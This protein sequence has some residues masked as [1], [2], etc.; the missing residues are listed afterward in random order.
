[1]RHTPGPWEYQGKPGY[2]E[3][4]NWF[5]DLWGTS[6][7]GRP[8]H[9]AD[10]VSE[11]DASLLKAAPDLLKALEDLLVVI[12]PLGWERHSGDSIERAHY[13]IY[14]A[15]GAPISPVRFYESDEQAMADMKKLAEG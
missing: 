10:V 3:L 8:V 11:Q 1:M 14:K 15:S 13:A 4:G 2:N 9:I 7:M 5:W 6:S 12:K